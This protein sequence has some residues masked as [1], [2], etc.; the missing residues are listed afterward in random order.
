LP[1]VQFKYEEAEKAMI[2]MGLSPDTARSFLEMS[3]AFN[4]GIIK[5]VE[6]TPDNT[7]ATPFEYFAAIFAEEYCSANDECRAVGI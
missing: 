4:D 2:G 1:Y 6:R 7:T 3:L 5:R